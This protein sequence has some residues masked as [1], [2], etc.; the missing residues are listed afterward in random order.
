M[1]N[2]SSIE[3]VV[4]DWGGVC[5]AEG[6]PFSLRA[7]QQKLRMGP[8]DIANAVY[9][10]YLDFYRGKFE[11]DAF[12]RHVLNHF[13]LKETDEINPAAMTN[14]YLA[15]YSIYDD[16]LAFASGLKKK[17]RVGLLSNLTPVMRDHIRAAHHTADIFI[18]EIFSC[19]IGVREVKPFAKPYEVL[20]T[21]LNA[22]PENVLFIDNSVKN[23]AAAEA[24]GIQ[25]MLFTDRKKFFDDI[26]HAL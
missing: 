9:D 18:P 17:C 10:A 20:L 23:V 4:F 14:A 13:Q 12:W 24:L 2:T 15:S 16:M 22:K 5:C 7:L 26:A 21:A 1:R 19:D 3:A 6:E 8:D 11:T 25:S